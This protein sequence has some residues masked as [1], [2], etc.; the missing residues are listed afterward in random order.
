MDF[1]NFEKFRLAMNEDIQ[2]IAFTS[3]TPNCKHANGW[4]KRITLKWWIFSM[5]EL[6]FVC[7]DCRDCIPKKDL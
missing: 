6:Y 3:T 4:F 1:P 7:T 2:T 5:E